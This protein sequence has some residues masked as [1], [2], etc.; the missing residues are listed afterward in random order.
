M[1]LDGTYNVL[2]VTTRKGHFSNFHLPP[3]SK[4]AKVMGE[5]VEYNGRKYRLYNTRAGLNGNGL[6]IQAIDSDEWITE[7][8]T[9][10]PVKGARL[11]ADDLRKEADKLLNRNGW[12]RL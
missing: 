6:V 9:D 8:Y 1:H 7:L 10:T 4:Y 11:N 5:D 3:Y 2:C 12:E